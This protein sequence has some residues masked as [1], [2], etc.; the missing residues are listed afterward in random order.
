VRHPDRPADAGQTAGP[1][2]AGARGED[3]R[4]APAAGNAAGGNAAGGSSAAGST[5]AESGSGSATSAGSG[6]VPAAPGS[7]AASP[8]RSAPDVR[9]RLRALAGPAV[10]AGQRARSSRFWPARQRETRGE[11]GAD[12]AAREDVAGSAFA[13][14]TAL[15]ALLIMAWLLPG[16]ALLLAGDF[17]PVPM[18]L[19]AVPLAAALAVNGLR[20]VPSRWPRLIPGRAHDRAWASW[21]GLMAT[22]AIA[23]GYAAWQLVE[24]SESIIVLRDP[25]T[26]L[27]AGYW[28][29]EHGSL[30]IPQSL[31]AFGGAHPALG[32]SSIGFFAH[33]TS[34]VPAATSGLPLLLA[35]GFWAHGTVGAT[36][37]APVLGGLA[38]LTFGGLIARLAGP[39]WAPAGALVLGLSLPEQYTS[40]APFTEP[41]IQ[42]LLFGGLCLL[43]DAMVMRS[44]LPRPPVLVFTDGWRRWVAPQRW[45][46]WL[47]PDRSMAGLA[48]LALGLTVLISPSALLYLLPVIPFAGLLAVGQRRLVVPFCSGV[49]FGVACGLADGYRLARPFLDSF[50]PTLELSGVI[51]AW[52]AA[53]TITC[54]QLSRLAG[55]RAFLRRWL[56]RR[57]LRWLPELAG[58]LVIAGLIGFAVR[59]YVQTV[60]GGVSGAVAGYVASL[61]L[62]Q[63]LP[64][65]PARLYAEDTLYWVIWYIG[66]PTVLLGGFGAALLVRRSVRALLTWQDP[67]GTWR[68]WALPLAII[69][70]G[71]AAVLW[72]PDIVP[73]QPW[74][75]RRLVVIVLPGLIACA[76][77]AAAWLTGRARSRGAQAITA[78]VAGLFCVAAFLV[79][80]VATTFGLGLTHSGPS[81]GLRPTADGMAFKRTGTGELTAVEG[82][83]SSIPRNSSV[84]I[85]NWTVAQQFSQVIRGMCGEPTAWM[86]GQP[87]SAVSSVMSAVSRSGRRPVLLG[88]TAG[89]LATFGGSP[90]QVLNLV[91][92]G[93]PHELTQPPTVPSTVHF[94]I[95]MD[96]PSAGTAGA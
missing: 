88:A 21:F 36:G 40:R 82:L 86:V 79:P 46:S 60:R 93:D 87:Q 34:V 1:G 72:R 30:P 20:E 67:T 94:T 29:A 63:H 15:P 92:A 84:V 43:I 56:A 91:T 41:A 16:L 28:I 22:V 12:E 39:R 14:L 5:S 8:Q 76:L 9:S 24:H 95:W 13:R 26:Y 47:T 90:V 68:N 52:L 4:E 27:Q 78:A 74:A 23:A 18:L 65:D 64:V 66:L 17:V 71:S 70:A 10:R 42:V 11:R 83:C 58:L 77:W 32:F 89:E 96:A 80:T 59:P 3:G 35:G 19:I 38:V 53:L 7:A 25:G 57:P 48:G 45:G 73:D 85:V 33:G 61:Q 37:I 55:V 6:S 31:R 50:S 75:S 2:P 51:A 62:A 54:V 44:A 49:A 69:C 81:G